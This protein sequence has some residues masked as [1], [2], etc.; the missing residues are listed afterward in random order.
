MSVECCLSRCMPFLKPSEQRVNK[1]STVGLSWN[2][3]VARAHCN[4]WR[5]FVTGIHAV[6]IRKVAVDATEHRFL[7]CVHS[8]LMLII[9]NMLKMHGQQRFW[10][11]NMD[12]LTE[13]PQ[14]LRCI[15]GENAGPYW[16]QNLFL[17]VLNPAPNLLMTC[18]NIR[19][20]WA[21]LSQPAPWFIVL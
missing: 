17:S 16:E 3:C 11:E 13:S 14:S 1:V 12:C 6:K 5:N 2:K 9:V 19:F 20:Q 4:L 15:Y 7:H 21:H 8:R 18:L 10:L